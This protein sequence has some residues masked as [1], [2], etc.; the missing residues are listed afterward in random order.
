MATNRTLKDKIS[1]A[2]D[3]Y[4]RKVK[5]YQIDGSV[6]QSQAATKKVMNLENF[7]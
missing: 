5:L 3:R 6:L 1:V 4:K 2:V 7:V